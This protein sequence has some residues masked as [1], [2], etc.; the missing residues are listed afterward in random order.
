MGKE[1]EASLFAHGNE[2]YF[3]GPNSSTSY[4]ER[5]RQL[6]PTNLLDQAAQAQQQASSSQNPISNQPI[7]SRYFSFEER[8]RSTRSL[9]I[10]EVLE[11]NQLNG[12]LKLPDFET[13]LYILEAY[14]NNIEWH[15][16]FQNVG[17]LLPRIKDFHDWWIEREE[18]IE[19]EN[20]QRM[21]GNWNDSSS[22]ILDEDE[23]MKNLPPDPVLVPLL[24]AILAIGLQCIRTC[25]SKERGGNGVKER[26]NENPSFPS[27]TST[28]TTSNFSKDSRMDFLSQSKLLP[29]SFSKYTPRS[30]S[31]PPSHRLF[32][33]CSSEKEFL[34]ISLECSESLQTSCPSNFSSA[35]QAPLD[36]IRSNLLIGIWHTSELNLQFACSAF[37]IST[38]LAHSAGLNRDPKMWGGKIDKIEAFNRRTLW[39]S[40]VFFSV[41]HSSRLGIPPDLRP[42]GFDTELPNDFKT[43]V[44][45]WKKVDTTFQREKLREELEES[46]NNAPVYTSSYSSSTT[47]AK[48]KKIGLYSSNYISKF[49]KLYH[50]KPPSYESFQFHLCRYKLAHCFLLQNEKLFGLKLPR[51]EI[52]EVLDLVYTKWRKEVPDFLKKEW[53]GKDSI[54][55]PSPDPTFSGGNSTTDSSPDTDLNHHEQDSNSRGNE[56][57][58]KEELILEENEKDIEMFQSFFLQIGYLQG[59]LQIHRPYLDEGGGWKEPKEAKKSLEMCLNAA[60]SLIWAVNGMLDKGPPHWVSI[61][62]WLKRNE[63][64]HTSTKPETDFLFFVSSQSE[65]VLPNLFLRHRTSWFNTLSLVPQFWQSTFRFKRTLPFIRDRVLTINRILVQTC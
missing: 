55:S 21:D 40:V 12:S 29:N 49:P 46:A 7:T 33:N 23:L 2:V 39:W 58:T 36:L 61:S 37:A 19:N 48:S 11:E 31:S 24:F 45:I 8:I 64:T 59:T 51:H 13:L 56:I 9:A 30:K 1:K 6:I 54:K 43:K 47:T 52:V 16:D 14:Q 26:S 18:A 15:Y 10:G 50:F 17:L 27:S 57:K 3:A 32:K 5:R 62:L 53:L 38:R 28:S 41:F 34:K 63:A 25:G 42:N 22:P 35:Y 65:S 4:L 20:Q 60:C 44:Y